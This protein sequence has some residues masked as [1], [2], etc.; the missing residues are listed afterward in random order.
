MT[1]IPENN[2]NIT[3]P[4]MT[5]S[6]IL[7]KD[8]PPLGR[9]TQAERRETSHRKLLDAAFEIVIERG[10][11]NFTLGEIGVRAGY[12]RGLCS[13]VF[14]SKAELVNQL[15]SHL[16]I[17]SHE[18]FNGRNAQEGLDNILSTVSTILEVPA[19]QRRISIILQVLIGKAHEDE[20]PLRSLIAELSRSAAGFVA[21]NLRIGME[22]GSVR[23]DIDP[24]AQGV[25][26]MSAVHGALRQWLI[27]PNRVHMPAIR[28]EMIANFI[29]SNATSPEVWIE[30]WLPSATA[31][32]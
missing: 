16:T 22:T 7:L 17:V 10:S 13:Q 24:H 12:S 6:H 14:G 9:R 19:E 4:I 32:C 15:V 1:A 2:L 31:S 21:N 29:R 26:L 30:R 25:L 18:L 28:H 23:R 11:L 5:V 3:Y 27:D 8:Y 20:S